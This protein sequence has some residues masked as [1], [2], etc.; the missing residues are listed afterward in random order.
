MT[1]P[2]P[3]PFSMIREFHLADWF[4]LGNAVCGTGALF[5]TMTFLAN[6]AAL[7]LEIAAALILAALVFDVLDGRIARW[8]QQSSAM[9]RELDSLADVISFG[10]APAMMGYACGMRGLYDRVI[11]AYFVACG[12]SRL[13]RYN[14]TAEAYA[15]ATGKVRWFEGTPIPTS[16][17]IAALLAAAA[18]AGALG[19]D[20]WFGALHLAGYTLH[21]LTLLFAASGTLMISRIRIPKP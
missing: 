3:K 15:A 2:R 12:V 18:S 19:D 20:L 7:H 9:G 4:T 21:P 17:V 16:I 8:R 5:S 11:L 6:G 13:A 10:V 14:V 1:D